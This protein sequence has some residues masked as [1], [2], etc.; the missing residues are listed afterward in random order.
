MKKTRVVFLSLTLILSTMISTRTVQARAEGENISPTAFVCVPDRSLQIVSDT[1]RT[2]YGPMRTLVNGTTVT[3]SSSVSRTRTLSSTISLGTT[4]EAK[5]Q[6]G[7]V[8]ATL[9]RTAEVA[10]GVS[11]TETRTEPIVVPPKSTVY[12]RFGTHRK[13]G[14][15][16]FKIT[17]E[18]CSTSYTGNITYDYGWGEIDRWEHYPF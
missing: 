4:V 11:K 15:Y 8:Q 10:L 3:Q 2:E 18:D 1:S 9:G 16:R 6:F 5:A 13:S 7:L 14:T 17:Y 12:A